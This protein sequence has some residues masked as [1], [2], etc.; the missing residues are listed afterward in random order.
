MAAHRLQ[1][2]LNWLEKNKFN[3]GLDFGFKSIQIKSGNNGIYLAQVSNPTIS[4]QDA[5]DSAL[6]NVDIEQVVHKRRNVLEA[7]STLENVQPVVP[8]VANIQPIAVNVQPAFDIQSIAAAN[9]Q[10]IAV[11]NSE[12]SRMEQLDA[13][14][15]R[16]DQRLHLIL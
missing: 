11:K 3:G 14:I 6:L 4:S 7:E 15:K 2:E 16:Y 9:N 12:K 13:K 1:V 8:A 10:P 5:L